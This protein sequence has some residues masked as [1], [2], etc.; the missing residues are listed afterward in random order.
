MRLL[1]CSAIVMAACARTPQVG[2]DVDPTTQPPVGADDDDDDDA[3]SDCANT[4]ADGDGV[5]ACDDCDDGDP[6]TYPHAE[7]RC[8][9]LD[10]DCDGA[11][12]P[13][14]LTLDCAD[15]DA[16]G[17]WHAT[18]DEQGTALQDHLGDLTVDQV[19]FD[20]SATTD[21]M[22]VTLDEVNG[23]V[24]CVY[25]GRTTSVASDKPDATD[26]NTEHSWPQS[27]GAGEV[28][29]RCDLHHLYPTDA[30]TNNDRAHHPFGEVVSDTDT[31]D[32]G[33][34]LGADA[35]GTTVFEPRH[36]HKG[37]IARSMLYFAARYGY[38]L[39]ASEVGL[40]QSWS[41]FDPVDAAELDRTWAIAEEQVLPNPYVVCPWLVDAL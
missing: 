8:D 24:E 4:D 40:Y 20:Y 15:C 5:N 31:I 27:Q 26:M 12:H 23:Q 2:T 6:A 32:G 13:E 14:E 7:E 34:R 33:S 17:W 28:P 1:W 39:S 29:A 36:E 11:P 19:C 30:D 37:N 38:D 22:F 10:N 16:A 25:T 3:T 18:R 41:L 35:S 9:G 21:F